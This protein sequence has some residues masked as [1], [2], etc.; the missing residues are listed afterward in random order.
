MTIPKEYYLPIIIIAYVLLL[1]LC[2]QLFT[3][4]R[5]MK[6]SEI[7]EMACIGL[8]VIFLI[9]FYVAVLT[10]FK[11]KLNDEPFLTKISHLGSFNLWQLSHFILY[12]ILASI[13]PNHVYLLFG[14]S[15]VWEL[16][17]LLLGY[18]TNGT[19]KLYNFLNNILFKNENNKLTYDLPDNHF[20]YASHY[21]II[22]NGAGILAG[23]YLI[24]PI[25][26]KI[27]Y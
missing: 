25:Y 4:L 16:I 22:A 12:A 6:F 11:I 23:L 19:S 3:Y 20:W 21:D 18:F 24:R 8:F 1:S 15:I 27:Y 2:P 14:L 13:Y 7:A 10:I 26:K 5:S 17:E 9:F